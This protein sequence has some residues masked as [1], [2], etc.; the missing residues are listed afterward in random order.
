[1]HNSRL[2]DFVKGIVRNFLV[3]HDENGSYEFKCGIDGVKREKTITGSSTCG[4]QAALKPLPDL[5]F[6]PKVGGAI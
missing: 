3:T 2:E 1:M 6:T 5:H 4:K